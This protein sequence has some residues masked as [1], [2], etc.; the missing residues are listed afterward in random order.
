MRRVVLRQGVLTDTVRRDLDQKP[1]GVGSP[2]SRPQRS[3]PE[4]GDLYLLGGTRIGEV[5]DLRERSEERWR[6]QMLAAAPAGTGL[7]RSGTRGGPQHLPATNRRGGGV[8]GP[9]P[10]P[11]GIVR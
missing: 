5:P 8:A 10:G 7:R 6:T 9:E 11:T 1:G 4:G 3:S 2:G